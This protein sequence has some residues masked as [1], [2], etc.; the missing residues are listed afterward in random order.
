MLLFV[1]TSEIEFFLNFG[2]TLYENSKI[3][4]ELMLT[5]YVIGFNYLVLLLLMYISYQMTATRW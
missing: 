4:I 5:I 2:N 1:N 3:I